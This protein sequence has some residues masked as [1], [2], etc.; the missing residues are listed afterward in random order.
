MSAVT[1]ISAA[2]KSRLVDVHKNQINREGELVIKSDVTR[3]QQMNLADALDKLRTII[4]KMEEPTTVEPNEE[5]LE[6]IRK[7]QQK[8]ARIRLH[9]KRERSMIKADRQ[10]L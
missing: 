10:S 1:F 6:K 4:R 5:T 7:R 2:I 8:A 9:E 3:S